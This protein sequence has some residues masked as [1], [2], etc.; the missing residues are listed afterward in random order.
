VVL[1]IVLAGIGGAISL[2]PGTS[3]RVPVL[4]NL[5]PHAYAVDSY[6]SLMVENGTLAQI[7][8][9]IGILLAM[10]V[11]FFLVAMRRFKYE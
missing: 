8:P 1:G 7:L 2:G 11:V 3:T 5:T 9:E 6:Y 10:G 4:A